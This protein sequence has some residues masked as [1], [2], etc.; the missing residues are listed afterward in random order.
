[1]VATI[2][3]EFNPN[4]GLSVFNNHAQLT[5]EE[6]ERLKSD[7]EDYEAFHIFVT[8]AATDP[9]MLELD[10]FVRDYQ[11][12]KERGSDYDSEENENIG[13]GRYPSPMLLTILILKEHALLSFD[14][15]ARRVRYDLSFRYALGIDDIHCSAPSES[16]IK[17]FARAVKL[18]NESK[19]LELGRSYS[20]FNEVIKNLVISTFRYF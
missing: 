11:G 18:F 1:M 17:S 3:S 19:S 15:L 2:K 12:A 7:C 20:I 4:L 5:D 9:L 8:T 10:E 6:Y 16:K 13:A 14:L